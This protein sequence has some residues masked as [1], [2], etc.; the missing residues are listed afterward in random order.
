MSKKIVPAMDKLINDADNIAKGD[1]KAETMT[2]IHLRR[3][4]GLMNWLL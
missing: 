4:W 1:K 2:D 3:P